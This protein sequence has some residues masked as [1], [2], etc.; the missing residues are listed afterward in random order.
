[1]ILQRTPGAAGAVHS[2][3]C[4]WL[5]CKCIF[6]TVQALSQKS[7]N[8][9]WRPIIPAWHRVPLQPLFQLP[10]LFALVSPQALVLLSG[11]L[12]AAG[13][14]L[15]GTPTAWAGSMGAVQATRAAR[16]FS[17]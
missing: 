5:Y 14:L 8:A 13:A 4:A 10:A 15:H 16:I 17:S 9:R 11:R 12:A 3:S 2:I 6:E 7:V 1:M